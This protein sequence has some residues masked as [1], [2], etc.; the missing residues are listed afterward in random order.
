MRALLRPFILHLR[1]PIR[2]AVFIAH[3]MHHLAAFFAWIWMLVHVVGSMATAGLQASKLWEMRVV[4]DVWR[5]GIQYFSLA[6]GVGWQKILG[7]ALIP[8]CL[9]AFRNAYLAYEQLHAWVHEHKAAR[10]TA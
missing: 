9:L 7:L 8:A 4:E 10:H 1:W 5:D 2:I 3:L 6:G